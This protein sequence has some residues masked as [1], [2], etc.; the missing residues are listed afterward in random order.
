MKRLVIIIMTAAALANCGN[1]KKN[2]KKQPEKKQ[3]EQKQVPKE[4][5]IVLESDDNMQYNKKELKVK[6]GQKV[7]LTLKHIGK[8]E[9]NVM[10]HNFVLLKLNVKLSAFAEKAVLAV[11]TDYIPAGTSDI[12]VHTK[13]IGGGESDTITFDAPKKGTYDFLCT[14]PGHYAMMKGKFI[15][16]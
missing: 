3:V 14:F 9:K 11:E 12:I 16:E 15:V 5:S 1:K 6:E 10:G 7:T 13:L 4:I 2:E 8:M